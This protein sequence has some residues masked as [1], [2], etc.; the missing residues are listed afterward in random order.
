MVSKI[1]FKDSQNV[2]AHGFDGVHVTLHDK[3]LWLG[4][5]KL[6]ATGKAGAKDLAGD[7]KKHIAGDYLR[8]EFARLERKLPAAVPEIEYWRSLMHKHRKLSDIYSA[9]V[10]PMVCTYSSPIFGTHSDN[11]QDYFVAFEEECREVL[12]EFNKK[13][14]QT[15]CEVVLLTLPVPCKNELNSELD[16]RLKLM[17]SI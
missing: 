7:L 12:K 16:K 11:T 8:R 3:K 5:S 2:P 15:D 14:I 4:E 9:I 1:Y 17:Q 10:I 13:R 6:Y